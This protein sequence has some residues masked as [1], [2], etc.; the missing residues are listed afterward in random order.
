MATTKSNLITNLDA[1]P[2]VMNEVG[3]LG[4][5]VRVAMDTFEVASADMDADGDIVRL[6][7][8][9][10]NCRV[11]SI[12]LWSDDMGGS[13][14]IDCG[15]YPTDSDTAKDD[16]YYANNFDSSGQATAGTE[17]RFHT[18]DINTAS[19]YLWESA[20]DTSDPGGHYD[21]CLTAEA[22]FSGAYTCTFQVL[23]T[24]D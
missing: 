11:F 1:N 2:S 16:N 13:G 5:R 8:L 20:G 3:L 15:I 17:L 22:G 7:R 19:K 14:T 6:V 21:I 9:P 10:T 4:A 24:I 12:K 23:Y 18:A